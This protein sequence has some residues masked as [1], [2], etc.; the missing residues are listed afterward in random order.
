MTA[1]DTLNPEVAYFR[2]IE[3]AFVER[4]GDP[5]F[6]SNAD[7]VFLAKLKKRGVPLR[8]VLRGITDAFDAHVHSFSRKQKIRTL[9]FCENEIM[10]AVDRHRRALHAEGGSRRGLE[11]ALRK[12][13]QQLSAVASG[14]AL[15]KA[16]EEARRRLNGVAAAAKADTNF[17]TGAALARAEDHLANAILAL[18]GDDE[19]KALNQS[20]REA[21]ASYQARMPD[22]VYESLIAESVRRKLLQRFGLPR[23]HMADLE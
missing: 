9:K 14:V 10:A 2:D 5:L 11:P 15:T 21:T 16:I 12:L 13:D 4:R 20:T 17:D 1:L 22:R 8:V 6:I 19:V 23:F 18:V 3:R 7:W